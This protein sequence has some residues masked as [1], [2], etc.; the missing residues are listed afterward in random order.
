MTVRI[1]NDFLAVERRSNAPTL[2]RFD[3]QSLALSVVER[4]I[5]VDGSDVMQFVRFVERCEFVAG[6][7]GFQSAQVVRRSAGVAVGFK[8]PVVETAV[9]VRSWDRKPEW[10][11]WLFWARGLVF[12]APVALERGGVVWRARIAQRHRHGLV[13][14]IGRVIHDVLGW[15]GAAAAAEVFPADRC[16]ILPLAQGSVLAGGCADRGEVQVGPR[17]RAERLGRVPRVH[18]DTSASQ[19]GRSQAGVMSVGS[20]SWASS[21]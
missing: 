13:A 18:S 19:S 4:R 17:L 21:R 12:V 9:P 10:L 7:A 11:L 3:N 8:L 6:N 16:R 15:A 1:A 14:R 20:S 5:L 2:E